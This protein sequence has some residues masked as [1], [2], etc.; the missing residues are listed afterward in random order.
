VHPEL[1]L[2]RQQFEQIAS[3]AADLVKGLGEEEF[4]WRPAAG[5]WS[6]EECLA[7]L[8]MVGHLE[9]GHIERAID[10]ARARGLTAAGPFEYPAWERLILRETE[11]PVRHTVSAPKRFVPVHNQPLTAVMPTFFHVHR[12]F[13]LQLERADGLDLRRVKVV[14]PISRLLKVSLGTMFAQA[15]AHGRR[16]LA[17]ARRVREKLPTGMPLPATH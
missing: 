5:A 9:L 1:E 13:C 16:H 6:I 4:N 3:D 15:A 10:D 17:Q 11:P 2:Y 12:M 8:T 7:H 14:T